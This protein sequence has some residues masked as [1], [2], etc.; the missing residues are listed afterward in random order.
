MTGRKDEFMGGVKEGLGKMTGNEGL[1]AEGKAQKNMG[2]AKREMSGAA[3]EAKGGF[4]KA[5][6]KLLGSPTLQ[7]EGEVEKAQGRIE[8]S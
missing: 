1:E 4:K 5:A 3:H 8:R 6:G 7:A 2:E